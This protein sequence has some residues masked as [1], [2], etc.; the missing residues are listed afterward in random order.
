[1][2]P[3]EERVPGNRRLSPGWAAPM[4]LGNTGGLLALDA[5]ADRLTQLH[6]SPFVHRRARRVA[7]QE[8]E[9]IDAVGDFSPI[10]GDLVIARRQ[11]L[12]LVVNQAPADRVYA[13]QHIRRAVT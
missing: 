7:S 3:R 2:G 1:M 9:Q 10:P 8:P 4:A 6:Q 5:V 11:P 12:R 13:Q